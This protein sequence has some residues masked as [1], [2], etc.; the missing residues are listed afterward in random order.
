MKKIKA[1]LTKESA[2]LG[3]Y[4]AVSIL[5]GVQHLLGGPSKFNN[6]IIF[7]QSLFHLLNKTNLH[8]LYPAEYFDIFLYH[9]S[10]AILFTPFALMP[11]SVGLVSWLV[12]CSLALFYA[13][14][15]LPVSQDQKVFFWWFIL[16]ELTTSLHNQQTNPLLAALG[17]FTFVY[18]EKG[19]PRLASLFPVLAFCI[20]G[21]GAIFAAL[22]LFYPKQKNY[23]LYSVLWALLLG[24]LPLPVSGWEHFTVLYKD[25]Y[26]CL[27]DDYKI[28]YGFSIMGW[29]K[30]FWPTFTAVGTV[31][32]IGVL[33]F[34]ITWVLNW[35]FARPTFERR[36]LL[37]AYAS[38]WVILF[39]HAAESPTYVIA[40]VGVILFYLVNRYT[41]QPWTTILMIIAFFFCV[42]APTDVYPPSLRKDFFLPY[43]VKVVPCFLIWSVLQI[44]LLY[45]NANFPP[46]KLN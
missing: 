30:A 28:N 38:L 34:G 33:F 17:L 25:W 14:R 22:F 37:L 5:I 27:I 29:I 35:L 18:L 19:N 20:K 13:I 46:R 40:V 12:F 31:Q 10:F 11:T 9:P 21:Y 4:I 32:L 16:I 39:N 1:F 43:L 24:L 41:L 44:Q 7:K 23:I 36:M 45:L 26:N 15:A 42:L 2:I 6:F 3:V 8:S